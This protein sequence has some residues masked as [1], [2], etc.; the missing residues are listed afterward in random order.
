MQESVLKLHTAEF[1]MSRTQLKLKV[2]T[3]DGL[4]YIK[5]TIVYTGTSLIYYCLNRNDEMMK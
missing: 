5:P 4:R 3:R 1:A 2:K